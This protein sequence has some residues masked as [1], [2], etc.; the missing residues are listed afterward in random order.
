M[1]TLKTNSIEVLN[2]HFDLRAAL[3]QAALKGYAFSVD[4][5]TAE[6]CEAIEE[7][8]SRLRF[9]AGDYV[10][11]PIHEY[12]TTRVTQAH[13]RAYFVV[14]DRQIPVATAVSR[15]L[16]YQVS[17]ILSMAP[18]DDP[19]WGLT[20]WAP[21]EAGYQRYRNT[22]DHISP[23]RD[24]RTDQLLG[25]T[26]TVNGSALVRIH[27]TLGDPNDYT[28]TAVIDEFQA[29][30]GG[31]MLLRAPGFGSGEQEIHEVLPPTEGERLILNLR[32]RPDV[33]KAPN[34]E[35]HHG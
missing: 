15:A 27:R 10:T 29:E 8:A 7:E 30:K 32:M 21:T 16:V 14:G 5:L 17:R 18:I 35:V 2:P 1:N 33:L 24:R 20:D 11:K 22:D 19:L 31:L 9:E 4:A 12:K 28:N 6:A 13:E 23:H 34:K 26:A 25:A 3:A